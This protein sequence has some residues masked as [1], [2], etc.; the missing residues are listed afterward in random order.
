M[1]VVARKDRNGSGAKGHRKVDGVEDGMQESLRS[2]C[3]KWLNRRKRT[4][5]PGPNLLFWTK[6]MLAARKYRV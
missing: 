6:R 4:R 5:A 3:Q 1:P 2:Q